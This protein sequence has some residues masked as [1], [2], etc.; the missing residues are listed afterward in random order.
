MASRVI[1]KL[2]LSKITAQFLTD[3][4]NGFKN[5]RLSRE[6]LSRLSNKLYATTVLTS[7]GRSAAEQRSHARSC[8]CGR[9]RSSRP[10]WPSQS[11]RRRPSPALRDLPPQRPPRAHAPH[12]RRTTGARAGTRHARCAT[13]LTDKNPP[14]HQTNAVR[15]RNHDALQHGAGCSNQQWPELRHSPDNGRA[16]ALCGAWGRLPI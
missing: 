7:T 2:W 15:V 3:S 11:V 1:L 13:S 6:T 12:T 4:C 10:D 16:W 8:G 14:P 9:T 5:Q